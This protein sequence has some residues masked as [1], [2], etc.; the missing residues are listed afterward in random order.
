MFI[1]HVNLIFPKKAG[2]RFGY[3]NKANFG[4]TQVVPAAVTSF[5][6]SNFKKNSRSCPLTVAPLIKIC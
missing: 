1:S 3:H 2:F 4:F 5:C 6:N